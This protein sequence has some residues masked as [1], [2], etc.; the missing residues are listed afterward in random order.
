M[1][2]RSFRGW[3]PALTGLCLVCASPAAGEG[4]LAL[5]EVLEAVKS[6]PQLVSQ[7]EVAKGYSNKVATEALI[8]TP[9][10][11]ANV[12]AIAAAPSRLEA[13]HFGVA[14]YAETQHIRRGAECPA[15]PSKL[16]NRWPCCRP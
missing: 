10:G 3:V 9:L 8:E 2:T 14:D 15:T 5:A 13:M 7:I 16:A 6:E 12:E 11:M 4:G 1:P